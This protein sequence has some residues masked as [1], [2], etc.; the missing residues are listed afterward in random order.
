MELPLVVGPTRASVALIINLPEGFPHV[1]PIIKVLPAVAQRW[2]DSEMRVV[3]HEALTMWNRNMSLGKIVKDIEIE[4]NLRPPTVITVPGMP[5]SVASGH[6]DTV[7]SQT[8][9]QTAKAVSSERTQRANLEFSE[10]GA[11][12]YTKTCQSLIFNIF[13]LKKI[14]QLLEN[15]DEFEDFFLSCRAVQ[16]VRSF[17]D[18]LL[19]SNYEMASTISDHLG[20]SKHSPHI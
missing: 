16:E 15:E 10:V 11:L 2:V 14:K 19:R 20:L 12:K 5:F 13:S 8:A 4:F 7:S 18:E 17:Q 6:G 9:H 3:G 1:P